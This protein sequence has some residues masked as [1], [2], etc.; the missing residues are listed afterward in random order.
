M[1]EVSTPPGSRSYTKVHCSGE[2][3]LY[4]NSVFAQLPFYLID[5]DAF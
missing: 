1:V 3:A 5:R 2:G 4:F